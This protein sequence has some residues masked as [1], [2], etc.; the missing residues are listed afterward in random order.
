MSRAAL[1]RAVEFSAGH[2][3][4]RE[5]W[6]REEN[7]AR[8]GAAAS[9]RGHG[10][11]Y[12]CEVTVSGPVD[13]ETGMVVDLGELDRVLREEVREPMHHAFLNDL[14]DFAGE[15]EVPTTENIARVVWDRV[16]PRLPDGCTL[17]R[18]RVREGRDL[19]SDYEGG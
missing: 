17:L 5:E 14:P 16:A 3:Y 7:V 8:F 1:T 9:E 12:R 15:R 13:P 11:D 2:R 18:V 6:D 19:W 4:A 10:H